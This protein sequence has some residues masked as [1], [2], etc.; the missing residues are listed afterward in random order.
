M[1]RGNAEMTSNRLI[2]PGLVMLAG[3]TL[4][5]VSNAGNCQPSAQPRPIQVSVD[6]AGKPVVSV[7][8]LHACEGD[9]VRWIFKGST[10]MEFAVIFTDA[11]NSPFDWDRQTGATV[12]GTVRQGAAKNGASTSYKY[13]VDVDGNVLD[14]QIIVDP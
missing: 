4:S 5:P 7:D 1:N 2:L 6:A 11:A 9:T 3:L 12:T 13:S 14:P 8:S 10:A